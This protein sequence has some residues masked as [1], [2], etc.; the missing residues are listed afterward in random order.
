MED[1]D[2][3]QWSARNDKARRRT[4]TP[5]E[6]LYHETLPSNKPSL[7]VVEEDGTVLNGNGSRTRPTSPETNL[8]KE[9]AS[10]KAYGSNDTLNNSGQLMPPPPVPPRRAHSFVNTNG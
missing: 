4:A 6:L 1:G 10:L 3:V 2:A 7:P 9:P 5:D 8:V